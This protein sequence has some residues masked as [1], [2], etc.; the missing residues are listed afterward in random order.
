MNTKHLDH[1]SLT[2]YT[3]GTLDDAQRED[4]NAHLSLCPM[5]R[6]KLDEQQQY[7]RQI[8]NELGAAVN[9]ANPSSQMTFAAIASQ[10]QANRLSWNLWQRFEVSAPVALAFSG[11][12]LSLWGLW[13]Y[14]NLHD[15][16][17]SSRHFSTL[18]TLACFFL[19]LASVEEFEKAFSIRPRFALIVLVAA[20]LWLGSAFIGLLNILIIRDL[21]IM[22]VVA[23]GGK[24]AEAGPIVILAVMGAALLYIGLVIGGAEYHYRNVGQPN[25]WKLFSITLLGQL[26]ILILPYLIN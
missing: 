17:A 3:Y 2:G 18:P 24:A 1:T 25:S 7:M 11:L 6:G 26:F 4:I 22:A 21:A 20:I 14:I 23:L 13:Q 5:C 8:S 19:L 12:L 16:T 9:Q 15:P 10:L